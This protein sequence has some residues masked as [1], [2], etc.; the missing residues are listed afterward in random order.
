MILHLTNKGVPPIRDPSDLKSVVVLCQPLSQLLLHL[1]SIVG[2]RLLTCTEQEKLM[3]SCTLM[4][5]LLTSPPPFLHRQ[6]VQWAN[7][8]RISE[9]KAAMTRYGVERDFLELST[10]PIWVV[11]LKRANERRQKI[12]SQM[13]AQKIGFKFLDA[14]DGLKEPVRSEEVGENG[15]NHFL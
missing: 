8:E 13:D 10:M 4:S 15:G 2:L 5:S 12:Q 11:S 6:A 3:L 1:S 7:W 9:Q 14:I